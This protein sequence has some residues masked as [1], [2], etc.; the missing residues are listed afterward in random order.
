MQ[1]LGTSV[2]G[3]AGACGLRMRSS[4]VDDVMY[5]HYKAVQ[6]TR[7]ANISGAKVDPQPL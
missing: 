7:E 3:G 2:G 6:L 5:D 4:R 1:V